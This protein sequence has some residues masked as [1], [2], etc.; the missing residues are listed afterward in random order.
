MLALLPMHTARRQGNY[1]EST[2]AR[3]KLLSARWWYTEVPFMA[4]LAPELMLMRLPTLAP[5]PPAYPVGRWVMAL[6]PVH[7]VRR[8]PNDVGG[9]VMRRHEPR[10]GIVSEWQDSEPLEA[11]LWSRIPVPSGDVQ[12]RIRLSGDAVDRGVS[13]LILRHHMAQ[14][15]AIS[16]AT[17]SGGGSG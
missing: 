4:T 7:T 5:L 8:Q 16:E 17:S 10:R 9:A 6:L 12:R 3:R 11:I 1:V 13:L 2:V 15:F 14:S